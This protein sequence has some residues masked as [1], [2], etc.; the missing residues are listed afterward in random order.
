[1]LA[2]SSP[3]LLK[4]GAKIDDAI[5]K[6]LN[7]ESENQAPIFITSLA[8]GGTTALLNAFSDLPFITTHTYRDMPFITAP[9]LWNRVS[10]S[11][12]RKVKRAERA[13]G[14]GLEIDLDS[15]EAFDEVY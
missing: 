8:R 4:L 13:H 10:K 15:P 3:T 1:M 6:L 2:F 7:P 11:F 9:Y 5:F 12:R 14:D